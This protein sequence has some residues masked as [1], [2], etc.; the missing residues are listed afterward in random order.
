MAI[1]SI[2]IKDF[3]SLYRRFIKSAERLAKAYRR[4]FFTSFKSY[5][6]DTLQPIVLVN[7]PVTGNSFLYTARLVIGENVQIGL[8]L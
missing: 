5:T 2:T 8:N 3:K 1:K 7:S 6:G 4:L